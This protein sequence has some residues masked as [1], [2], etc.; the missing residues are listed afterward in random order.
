MKKYLNIIFLVHIF[1]TTQAQK[2][3]YEYDDL[4]RLSKVWVYNGAALQHTVTYTYDEMGNR[5]GKVI[6]VACNG[7]ASVQTGYWNNAATWS[8]GRVPG[9]A[10]A[11]IIKPG[12]VVSIPP[13][14]TGNARSIRY[15]GGS[16]RYEAPNAALRLNTQ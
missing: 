13:N 9:S 4:N 3:T 10:D 1:L 7:M 16:I 6:E 11:V 15:E 8:C 5:L 12:H 2:R 14:H